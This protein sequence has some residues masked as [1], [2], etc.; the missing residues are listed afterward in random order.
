MSE[1]FLLHHSSSRG[2][3]VESSSMNWRANTFNYFVHT[4]WVGKKHRIIL[5]LEMQHY[6]ENIFSWMK[7]YF[8]FLLWSIKNL[9]N[10]F[11]S[12]YFQNNYISKMLKFYFQFLMFYISW[13]HFVFQKWF[14]IPKKPVKLI[15]FLCKNE[16][17][18]SVYNT[19]LFLT[20]LCV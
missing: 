8:L 14:I 17:L 18:F 1:L 3:I 5:L 7:K 13:K 20:F 6:D 15:T 10:I 4:K 12:L 11:C 2:T 19:T 16:N 9:L